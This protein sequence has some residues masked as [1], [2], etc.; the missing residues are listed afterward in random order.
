MRIVDLLHKQGINLNF[1]PNTKEQCINELVD[2]MDKTGNLNN[3]EEYKKAILAREELS[4]TGIGDG[5]AIPHGK[6][7]AVKKASLAA[8]ICKKGVDYDSLDGQP[9]HLFFMIAVP[10]NNDNLHLEVLAR[11]ST[12]LMDE[13]FRTS[14][15]DCSDKEEFLRLIDKKEMEKFPEEVKGELEMNK[16]GYRVL[17]VTACPTGIAHTY[18]AAESL[19]SKGKD[20]GV[21]IKVETNGSGGA[22]NVLT[23]E[24]IANAEC[25]II[26]ADKNVEMA[27]FDG[28]RVIKTKVADGIHKSA[29]L[30]EEAISG[31]A[32]IYHHA[33]GADSSEDVSNE[34]V[35]RQIYKHLMNGVSHML[36]FVIGGGILI[37]LAFLFDTFNPAN[38]S[39]FGSGTPIAAVLM[40]IGGTAFG[41]MLPVLAGFIAMSIGDRPA[42]SV[43]FV[44]GA[45]ASAG[46]TFASAFDP[47]VPAVSGGF[48]GALLAGFIAGYLVVGLKKLFAG[49]PN[50][51]EGIKP[52]FL[53]PLLG[54]F[55]IG[56]IMLFINPIMGSINTGIT[57]ALNSMG[58]T[59]KI[60]LGIVLGGMMSV[61]MGGPVNKAAYLFGT[62]SLASGNF[63]IMAA[64]MAGG[65]VPPL[66]IAICTTV[67]RNKFTEKDRQA[68][69]VNYIM[70]LSFIS[71]GAIPFA[72]ADPIRV[73]PSC[74]I[75]SA[76]A[77]ALSMA[78]GCALRAPHGGIFVIAIVTNPL[79]YLASIIIGAVVGA[80][81]LGIIKKPVQK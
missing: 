16:S 53:Y 79:Q 76:V 15:I 55:L 54:T 23:K 5:I 35:G 24:E 4:T 27:R 70:G 37:A 71:E 73:L 12:I 6:T 13:A 18:M 32:P 43:G 42:L 68:G 58:G 66:A 74:I 61:D 75:G 29:Q 65:M 51:L 7:S 34:S 50:S 41:F 26:A 2:L 21:S 9:A 8:A 67:F 25:I 33:G 80:I 49:L 64:V 72:A 40:K 57:G 77:G 46:I 78:F 47:K 48:L 44:G 45:L 22:K 17:A 20:M 62:A 31:N 38:P 63:D 39:G 14:L 56:V 60:L 81:I 10:D 36:P 3:K 1:N 28:K 19:E 52:V 69:L 11:L 59:S 30:I